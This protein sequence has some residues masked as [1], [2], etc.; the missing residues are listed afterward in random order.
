[1]IPVKVCGITNIE[2]GKLAVN[3]GASA[4]GLIFHKKSP[5]YIHPEQ[6]K[7]ITSVLPDSI[8]KVGVF[9]NSP[10]D[11]INSII[12][13]TGISFVQLHGDETP[14]FCRKIPLPVIKAMQVSDSLDMEKLLDF[15]AHAL[16]LDTYHSTQYG[17][18]GNPFDWSKHDWTKLDTPLILSGG[19]TP[20]NVLAGIN[21]LNPVAVDVNSGVE[22]SPGHKDERKIVAF[23]NV[24]NKTKS[25]SNIFNVVTVEESSI[26]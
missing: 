4:I 24:L 22:T 2:D 15:D 6:A 16:L 3:C 18:T 19:M 13:K 1:M 23:F 7:I 14:E 8:T 12:E 9:V 17:G 20:E 25:E 5:R 26:D 21:A 11:S 10:I